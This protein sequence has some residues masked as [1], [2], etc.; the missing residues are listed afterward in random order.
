MV[1]VE[2]VA[3]RRELASQSFGATRVVAPK[4]AEAA[5]AQ[6]TSGRGCDGVIEA[7]GT[8][9]GMALASTLLAHGGT[10]ACVG[11]P[12]S[13]GSR[14][15]AVPDEDNDCF[16][17]AAASLLPA[18][19]YYEK[20]ATLVFGRAEAAAAAAD[21]IQLAA[22]RRYPVAALVTH[23]LPLEEAQAAYELAAGAAE[24]ACIKALLYPHAGAMGMAH[25][26]ASRAVPINMGRA[27]AASAA[28]LAGLD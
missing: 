24:H 5:V 25:A 26:G 13:G 19:V 18:A 7:T 10:L 9:E 21:A 6:L 15:R 2:P 8:A 17:P 4:E 14:Q 22:T 28:E 16:R 20:A 3:A 23:R 11:H 1:G 12:C 27:G